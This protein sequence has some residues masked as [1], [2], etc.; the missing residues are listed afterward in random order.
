MLSAQEGTERRGYCLIGESA[1]QARIRIEQALHLVLVPR[2]DHQQVGAIVFHL[3]MVK[4]H[5][6]GPGEP[7][8]RKTSVSRVL[9]TSMLKVSWLLARAYASSMNKPCQQRCQETSH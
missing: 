5:G 9:M 4:A 1:W 3:V 2:E 8:A 7:I 6:D